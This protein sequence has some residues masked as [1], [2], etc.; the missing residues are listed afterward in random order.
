MSVKSKV[1]MLHNTAGDVLDGGDIMVLGVDGV[2]VVVA[3]I[4]IQYS[5]RQ[6]GQMLA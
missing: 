4:C 5:Y 1:A 3:T 6:F 2:V